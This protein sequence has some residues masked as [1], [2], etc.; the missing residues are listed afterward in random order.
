MIRVQPLS[1][2]D[3]AKILDYCGGHK[4]DVVN[5]RD[6][7]NC[8]VIDID[9]ESVQGAAL[10]TG[11]KT[12][13]LAKFKVMKEAK[14]NLFANLLALSEAKR[15]ASQILQREISD[16]EKLE[17]MIT[18]MTQGSDQ[19]FI[20][21]FTDLF[22]KHATPE[23]RAMLPKLYNFGWKITKLL[24]SNKTHKIAWAMHSDGTAA[25]VTPDGKINR[26]EVGKK[27]A[28]LAAKEWVDQ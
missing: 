19:H 25:W 9:R 21:A 2:E 24:Q 8:V 20:R 22:D 27:I 23:Q 15:D 3:R 26:A 13:A 5:E 1:G 12:N 17:L 16:L 11:L 6:V 18:H 10:I 28:T 4:A 14:M 7:D